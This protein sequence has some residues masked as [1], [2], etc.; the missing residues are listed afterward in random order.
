MPLFSRKQRGIIENYD[1]KI[2]LYA[3]GK[4]MVISSSHNMTA[5]MRIGLASKTHTSA[6]I[7]FV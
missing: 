6:S 4:Y 5:D 7:Y 2:I 1:I 3:A